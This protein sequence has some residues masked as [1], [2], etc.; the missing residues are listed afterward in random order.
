MG[1]D[2]MGSIVIVAIAVLVLAG[3][4]PSRTRLAISRARKHEADRFSTSLH[5]VRIEPGFIIPGARGTNMPQAVKQLSQEKINEIHNLRRASIRRRQILVVSL[6]VVTVVVVALAFALHFTPLWGLIPAALIAV[7]LFFGARAAKVARA[8]EEAVTQSSPD[9]SDADAPSTTPRKPSAI[10]VNSPEAEGLSEQAHEVLE[11]APT[12]VIPVDDVREVLRKQAAEKA[13]AIARRHKAR[14]AEDVENSESE[15]IYSDE[16]EDEVSPANAAEGVVDSDADSAVSDDSD[17]TS[18]VEVSA[19][20]AAANSSKDLISFSLGA[21]A[22]EDAP[23]SDTTV[24]SVKSAEIKSYRQVAKA[25]AKSEEEQ[26]ALRAQAAPSR[27]DLDQVEAP[28]PSVDSL[29]VDIDAV[30]ARR[31]S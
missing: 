11:T 12:Y 9:D 10:T 22:E 23:G 3:F 25:S 20:K 17:D 2:S 27:T 7:I 5:L 28:E 26:A 6:L 15:T 4:V 13:E 8:W 16:A 29:G 14:A 24:E 19:I 31:Q 30:I 1:F 21:D 18:M